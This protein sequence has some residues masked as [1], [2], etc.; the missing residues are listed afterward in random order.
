M[1]RTYLIAMALGMAAPAI[2]QMPPPEYA[3]RQ[4]DDPALEASARELMHELRCL[5]CQSQSIADSEAPMAQ[6]MRDE[7]RSQMAQGRSAE[8]VRA[9]MMQRYGDYVTF[10]PEL[11]AATWPLFALPALF[12]AIAVFLVW[13]RMATGRERARDSEETQTP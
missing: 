13:R 7:V 4:L 6:T 5:T 3:H 1:I 9:W 2:A 12:L 8:E 10:E 11:S